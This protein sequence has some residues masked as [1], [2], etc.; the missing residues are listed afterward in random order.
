MVNGRNLVSRRTFLA[1][2]SLAAVAGY[3]GRSWAADGP[4]TAAAP[5]I[6]RAPAGVLR[7]ETFA[8]VRMFRGIPFCETPAGALRFRPPMK[9]APWEGEHDATRFKASAMQAGEPGIAHSEDC[10]GLNIWAPTSGGPHP[11]FV[12]IHGGGFTAGHAFDAGLD[13]AQFARDGVVVVTVPYRLGIFGFL[14]VS[15]LLGSS[16]AGSANNAVKDL[17]ASLQWIREN[18][19]AFGGDPD[20]VT[21]GGE[22]AGGK[23]TCTLMGVPSAQPLFH[24]MISSSG[25]AERVWTTEQAAFVA[26]RFGDVWK[27]TGRDLQSLA[28]APATEL[29]DAQKQL[30]ADWPKD[31]PMQIPLRPEIDGE[32]FP[33]TPIETIAAGST[34]GKRF[35]V[36]TNLDESA[37]FIGAHP[38][39]VTQS[40]VGNLALARFNEIYSHYKSLYPDLSDEQLRIRAVS[41]QAYWVPS[42]RVADAHA[43]AAGN[44]WMYRLDFAESSGRLQGYA[45]HGLDVP[46]V[47]NKPHKDVT[48]AGAETKL[49]T[50]MHQAWVAFIRGEAPAAP[51]LPAWPEYKPET[52]DTMLLTGESR[53]ERK[54]HEAELRLW[55]GVL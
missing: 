1:G 41:A 8:G 40:N 27:K 9:L 34:R 46:L 29:A 39:E 51:G 13:G 21:V 42:V 26:G 2:T 12:W 4:K 23:L 25:G 20:R 49:S 43:K 17:I 32:F 16:Y 11:V 35:L 5:A 22:S 55:D 18:I 24:Q 28:T 44:T 10:L 14:D 3:A 52:R 36:G 19:S 50:Q 38:K 45:F 15:P 48:N 7:G 54:P 53:V 47:W 31:L 30:L 37:A 6:V 33:R